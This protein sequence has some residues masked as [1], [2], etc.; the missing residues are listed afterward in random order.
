MS[1]HRRGQ[2]LYSDD[3]CDYDSIIPSSVEEDSPISLINAS[4]NQNE[5]DN[6]GNIVGEFDNL[7]LENTDETTAVHLDEMQ[8][9]DIGVLL[10]IS[11][12]PGSP[13]L[14]ERNSR[15]SVI[16]SN[17]RPELNV[18]ANVIKYRTEVQP[19]SEPLKVASKLGVF[20]NQSRSL[21]R[22]NSS[23]FD[24]LLVHVHR[25]SSF[26]F[27]HNPPQHC[28]VFKFDT[29]MP[30]IFDNLPQSKPSV[31][32]LPK[33]RLTSKAQPKSLR[34]LGNGKKLRQ[35]TQGM[36][37]PIRGI[38]LPKVVNDAKI[39]T[40][41][42]KPPDRSTLLKAYEEKMTS[43]KEKE[44]INLVVVGHVDAGKSTLMGNVLLQLGLVSDKKFEKYKWE[45]TKQGRS[46]FAYAWILDQTSEER[47]R[48]ITMDI[49]QSAFETKT[50]RVILLD[51]PGHRDFIPQVIGGAA[52]ADVA[53][54][55]VNATHGEYETGLDK[56]GGQTQEHARLMRLL[57]ISRIIV[58]VNKMDTVD[59]SQARFE[60]IRQSMTAILKSINQTDNIF[61]PVSGLQGINIV[62]EANPTDTRDMN[63]IAP[64]YNGP[65]LL[66]II[67]GLGKVD[68]QIDAPFRFLV[69]DVF[70][71]VG[72]AAPII[73]GRVVSGAISSGGNHLPPS[74]IVCLPSG[75][76][77]TIRSIRPLGTAVEVESGILREQQTYA[78]AGDQVGLT[79]NDADKTFAP[80]PGDV[81]CDVDSRLAPVA[82]RIRAKVLVFDVSVPLTLGSP[83]IFHHF[84]S[85]VPARITKLLSATI[86]KKE[87]TKPRV[88]PGRCTAEIELTLETPVCVELFDVCKPL[89]RFILR[90]GHESV[91]GGTIIGFVRKKELAAA[92]SPRINK[93][94]FF[95]PF[96][97]F[98]RPS[99]P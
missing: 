71:T 98:V 1:R 84:C 27:L 32:P 18:L 62:P 67:D 78:F 37:V 28:T 4:G 70:K 44:I 75:K 89:G 40:P 35:V 36:S 73:A 93:L 57:G 20:F 90:A 29:E 49:A 69:S 94:S 68:R 63:K 2:R 45:S 15:P 41:P 50:K 21:G 10:N 5:T 34:D 95:Y 87:L 72:S 13:D 43:G 17:T 60:E 92:K 52:C 39:A 22:S 82:T 47:S 9:L 6:S 88:L 86:K 38:R 79:L 83:V 3:Y 24:A 8:E 80:T 66:D 31:P 59:W 51:A 25:P 33:P 65:T 74:K 54:L 23:R 55:V 58:A 46:S 99:L 96:T 56:A 53:I 14:V 48:G 11:K 19:I 12:A 16:K 77:A 97:D 61:C 30:L 81:I 91:A 42:P 7:N 76:V 85:N 26:V 64:W